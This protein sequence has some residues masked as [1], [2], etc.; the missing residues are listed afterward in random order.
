M[1]E[2]KTTAFIHHLTQAHRNAWTCVT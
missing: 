2:K 1:A